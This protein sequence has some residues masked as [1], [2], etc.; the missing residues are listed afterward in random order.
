[1]MFKNND[2]RLESSES[3]PNFPK[4]DASFNLRD[5]LDGTGYSFEISNKPGWYI[6]GV[7]SGDLQLRRNNGYIA[8]TATFSPVF[9]DQLSLDTSKEEVYGCT[10]SGFPVK[11]HKEMV[12]TASL[13]GAD[14]GNAATDHPT[15]GKPT[16]C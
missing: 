9:A 8:S 14:G 12:L 4:G 6:N 3:Y 11:Y 15:A 7:S 16:L 5:G 13:T 10:G 2:I 1:M